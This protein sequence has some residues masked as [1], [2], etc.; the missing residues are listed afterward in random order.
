MRILVTISRDYPLPELAVRKLMEAIYDPAWEA[1]LK[2]TVVHG[3]SQMD[4]LLAG[5]ALALG[6]EHEPHPYIGGLGRAG[7]P[8]RNQEMVDAGADLCLAFIARDSR[9]ARDCFARART[10]GIRTTGWNHEGR[11]V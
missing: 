7:G 2:V 5:A 10:A 1:E 6:Q 4:W 8:V 9:G 11:Q 3:A